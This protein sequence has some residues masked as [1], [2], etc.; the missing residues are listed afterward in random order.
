MDA[1]I[2]GSPTFTRLERHTE[3]PSTND[4]A[5]EQ[6]RAGEAPGLVVVADA[7]TAGRG[8]AGRP[9]VDTVR[10]PHGPANLAVTAT[11]RT[12]Q[13]AA[14]LAPLA[15]ALAVAAAYHSAGAHPELKWPNDVLLNGRKAAGV[16]I[17]RY[18]MEP[19]GDVLLIG[20]GL[21]LDWRDVERAGEQTEWT[22]LA[23]AIDGP[24]DREQVLADLL[25]ALAAKLERVERDP[26]GLL[27]IYRERCVTLGRDVEVV[28][29]DGEVLHAHAADI[30]EDGHLVLRTGNGDRT[31]LS[32]EVRHVRMAGG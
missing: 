26:A 19:F 27:T 12:P 29:P 20:C 8:R 17:E 21:D 16:L 32:G 24:V 1:A 10:G 28:L 15:A 9:W 4:L 3:V 31:I 30:D 22:S 6:L 14:G 13:R 2:P 18:D 23:E 5:L 7:Q 11:A 25:T